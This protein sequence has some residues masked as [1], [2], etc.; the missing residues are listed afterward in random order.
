MA[1]T[2]AATS[3]TLDMPIAKIDA[4]RHLVFGW[5]NVAVQKDGTPVEDLHGDVIAITDLEEAAY[6]FN[7]E[8]RATGE[9]HTGEAVGQLVES[10]VVTQEKLEKMG[11]AQHALPQGWWVGFHIPDDAIFAKVKEGAYTMFSIQGMGTREEL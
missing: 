2:N 6:A 8:F 1:E 11:L 10:F 9:M 4:D 7:L 3:T 5:A